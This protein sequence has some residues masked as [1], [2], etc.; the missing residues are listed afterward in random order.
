MQTCV[1]TRMNDNEIKT[2]LVFD[3]IYSKHPFYEVTPQKKQMEHQKN[4]NI[5]HSE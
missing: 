4:K 2:Y 5:K 3:S 1:Y